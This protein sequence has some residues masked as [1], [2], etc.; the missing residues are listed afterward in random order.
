[1]AH[2]LSAYIDLNLRCLCFH[3]LTSGSVS[4]KPITGTWNFPHFCIL[5]NRVWLHPTK[6]KHFRLQ[7]DTQI[8][9]GFA[10]LWGT[11]KKEMEW[12]DS[13]LAYWF[14][15]RCKNHLVSLWVFKSETNSSAALGNLRK[16]SECQYFGTR[17]N[18]L[19]PGKE[20]N[21]RKGVFYLDIICS[22]VLAWISK[23]KNKQ[24]AD[25]WIHRYEVLNTTIKKHS[26]KQTEVYKVGKAEVNPPC[27]EEGTERHT[28]TA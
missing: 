4:Q 14:I 8:W 10:N 24:T 26:K 5:H 2:M 7:S 17:P 12:E 21:K 18:S 9:V 15:C 19:V 1:M 6:Q 25:V 16:M 23:G 22:G 20:K 11:G 13:C 27:H 28:N 3:Y